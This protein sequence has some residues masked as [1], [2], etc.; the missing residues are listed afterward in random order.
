MNG[1]S[2]TLRD[3]DNEEDECNDTGL[4]ESHEG[5]IGEDTI[6][7]NDSIDEEEGNLTND[8]DQNDKEADDEHAP[9]DLF[10]LVLEEG[11]FRDEDLRL[12]DSTSLGGPVEI[13]VWANSANKGSTLTGEHL[14]ASDQE[15]IGVQ[16]MVVRA[17]GFNVFTFLNLSDHNFFRLIIQ[18]RFRLVDGDPAR[19]HGR[20]VNF[21]VHLIDEDAIGG[22][23]IASINLNDVSD[24]E[25][26]DLCGSW[27]TITSHDDNL[28]VVHFAP[29]T[30]PLRILLV[31]R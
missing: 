21:D 15:G 31:L 7:S 22:D 13:G 2:K 28:L 5:L 17:N 11:L 26:L 24:N 27:L 20:F 19:M 8:G 29:E 4:G 3:D 12:I 25:F 6:S 9:L 16:L 30:K 14:S 1:N 18:D 10:E 23:P